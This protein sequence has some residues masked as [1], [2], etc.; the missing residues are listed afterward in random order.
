MLLCLSPL[1]IIARHRCAL[2]SPGVTAAATIIVNLLAGAWRSLVRL[3]RAIDFVP[4]AL[5]TLDLAG[6][7][8]YVRYRGDIHGNTQQ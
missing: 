1:D 5:G 6:F 2:G 7:M 4:V 3:R 8:R